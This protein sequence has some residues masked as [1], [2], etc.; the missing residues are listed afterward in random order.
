MAKLPLFLI[1]RCLL[2][3]SAGWKGGRAEQTCAHGRG[4]CEA[5]ADSGAV[6]SADCGCTD[7]IPGAEGGN[8]DDRGG[9]YVH[10]HFILLCAKS[11][12]QMYL[13][14]FRKAAVNF[15]IHPADTGNEFSFGKKRYGYN[16]VWLAFLSWGAEKGCSG[17][18]E[19]D[20]GY[21]KEGLGIG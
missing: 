12:G 8:G 11:P 14:V 2:N 20:R 13:R 10:Y 18:R 16:C 5:S 21:R 6:D 15:L 9:A 19:P 17:E 7:G 4:V 1:F 3:I